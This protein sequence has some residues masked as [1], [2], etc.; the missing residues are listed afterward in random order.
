[1]LWNRQKP[2]ACEAYQDLCSKLDIEEEEEEEEMGSDDEVQVKRGVMNELCPLTGR[3][4]RHLCLPVTVTL[5]DWNV[6]LSRL[7]PA[8]S[9]LSSALQLLR[10][11]CCCS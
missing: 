2:E 1:M 4:V 10:G 7:Q 6:E 11:V 8:E 9:I 5:S 3:P